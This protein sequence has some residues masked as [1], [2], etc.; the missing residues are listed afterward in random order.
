MFYNL[1][2]AAPLL[3]VPVRA[4]GPVVP[5]SL[6]SVS[7]NGYELHNIPLNPYEIHDVPHLLAFL[8]DTLPE[9]LILYRVFDDFDVDSEEPPR[10]YPTIVPAAIT[11]TVPSSVSSANDFI[12]VGQLKSHDLWNAAASEAPGVLRHLAGMV[13]K[14]R[15]NI[16]AADGR[17]TYVYISMPGFGI[18]PVE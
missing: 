1:A 11:V 13:E 15:L 5:H 12:A 10:N 4:L 8:A 7:F 16:L 14:T 17:P 6:C 9:G 3:L 2:A 18:G